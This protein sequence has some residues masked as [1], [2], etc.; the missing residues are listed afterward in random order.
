M[1]GQWFYRAIPRE[2]PRCRYLRLETVRG[3]AELVRFACAWR[4]DT[5][6]RQTSLSGK[7]DRRDSEQKGGLR[8]QDAARQIIRH[9]SGAY[10][11]LGFPTA[12]PLRR[13][14]RFSV[15]KTWSLPSAPRLRTNRNANSCGVGHGFHPS[16][17]GADPLSSNLLPRGESWDSA[18]CPGARA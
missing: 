1:E 2:L 15:T 3:A 9:G 16:L 10:T 14:P 6:A 5:R 7:A 13:A 11:A 17:S 8:I 12:S 4:I 18:R